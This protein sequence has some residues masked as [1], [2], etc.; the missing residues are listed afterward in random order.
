MTMFSRPTDAVGAAPDSPALPAGWVGP[1]KHAKR[2]PSWSL[3]NWPVRWKVFAIALVPLVLAT[4]FGALRV[5]G[6]MVNARGLR[7]AATRAEVLPTITKYMSAL[8]VAILASSTGR[9]A[10]GAKKNYEARKGDRKSTRLN[11]SHI[12]KSRMPSSA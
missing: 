12:Q 6:E 9:D 8:D 2:P 10:E 1:A 11:S 5:E 4:I 3:S 7:V